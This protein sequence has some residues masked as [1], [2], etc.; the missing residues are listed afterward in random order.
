MFMDMAKWICLFTIWTVNIVGPAYLFFLSSDKLDQALKDSV[1]GVIKSLFFIGA[2][3]SLLTFIMS[4][5]SSAFSFAR[6]LIYVVGLAVWAIEI[7][8]I[9]KK[10][11]NN[12]S[13]G[14]ML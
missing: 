3:M 2:A 11:G 7:V 4:L 1:A 10:E 5:F 9:S 12:K 14:A 6:I 8:L 13:N